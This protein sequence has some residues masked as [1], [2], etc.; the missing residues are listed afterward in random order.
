MKRARFFRDVTLELVC[1]QRAVSVIL[2]PVGS[3]ASDMMQFISSSGV[4]CLVF[5]AGLDY[6]IKAVIERK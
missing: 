4:S 1:R 5:S 6:I 2:Y 3:G